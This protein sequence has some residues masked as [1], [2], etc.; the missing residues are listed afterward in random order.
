[1]NPTSDVLVFATPPAP[2]FLECGET[3]YVPG[4]QHPNRRQ[5]GVFDLIL[6]AS[7]RLHLGEEDRT[8]TLTPGQTLL[9]R[10]DLYHY[11]AKPCEE[12]TR[13]YWIHF[14][15]EFANG[16]HAEASA[17]PAV[18]RRAG[19]PA[20]AYALRIAKRWQMPDPAAAYRLLEQMLQA[21]GERQSS[22]FWAQ[23]ASFLELLR[24]MDLQRSEE[25][26]APTVAVAEQAE[27]YI[28]NRYR[29]EVTGQALSEALSYHYNYITRCMKQVYG[30]T[31]NAYLIHYRL[32]Q[33]KLLLLKTERPVAEIARAVGFEH[34]PY[35]TSCFTAKNGM[36]PRAFR[37]QY[38]E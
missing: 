33:A 25:Y 20:P 26:A 15:G 12:D 16:E 32:M 13:F 35:F 9:L 19:Y 28:R 14:Q 34:I 11:S 3:R 38:A 18:D 8:W 21:S 5:L 29:S 24:M 4:D 17:D 30:M 6:V 1:M 37:Q 27:A 2:Y 23:Q 31:P 10:P 7:G 22:A 36:S